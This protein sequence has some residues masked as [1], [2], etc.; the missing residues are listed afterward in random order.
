MGMTVPVWAE[1]VPT[2]DESER[3]TPTPGRPG[4]WRDRQLLP[5]S[6]SQ[7]KRRQQ[8]IYREM[9]PPYQGSKLSLLDGVPSTS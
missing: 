1:P 9:G 3:A 4:T 7:A 2:E 5:R 6:P 8:P